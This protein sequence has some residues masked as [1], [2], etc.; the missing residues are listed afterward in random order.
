MDKEEIVKS[1]MFFKTFEGELTNAFIIIIIAFVL[2][3]F[4]LN[5]GNEAF[6]FVGFILIMMAMLYSPFKVFILQRNK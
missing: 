6:Y 2:I 3:L 5:K 4:G 1:K